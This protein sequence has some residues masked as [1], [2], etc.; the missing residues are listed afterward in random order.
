MD[1]CRCGRPAAGYKCP[2][3]GAESEA[4]DPDHE[5][6]GGERCMAKCPECNEA[7]EK[8]ECEPVAEAV[9]EE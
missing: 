6:C 8:C 3:C 4:H 5:P 1:K 9:G 2:D 7:S